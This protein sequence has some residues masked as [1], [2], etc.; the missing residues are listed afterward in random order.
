MP[1][2]I[3]IDLDASDAAFERLRRE[4][5]KENAERTAKGLPPLYEDEEFPEHRPAAAL[6]LVLVP[7]DQSN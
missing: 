2:E 5:E 4:E 3:D 7:R 1:D 6:D